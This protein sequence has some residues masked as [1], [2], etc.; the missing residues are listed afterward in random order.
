MRGCKKT[1]FTSGKG[2]GGGRKA[3]NDEIISKAE[4]SWRTSSRRP[5]I[6]YSSQTDHQTE[7]VLGPERKL[8][9][10]EHVEEPVEEP[11]EIDDTENR[12]SDSGKRT[13]EDNRAEGRGE[14]HSPP[15]NFLLGISQE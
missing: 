13:M 12:A 6:Q 14:I 7:E 3:F 11:E 1:N 8:E 15:S 10:P 4:T 5:Q 9:T 2:T